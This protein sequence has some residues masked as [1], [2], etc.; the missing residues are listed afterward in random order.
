MKVLV[1]TQFHLGIGTQFMYHVHG[2]YVPSLRNVSTAQSL[3]AKS[4]EGLK[5]LVNGGPRAQ[6]MVR[7]W[8][9]GSA[10]WVFSM[11]VLGGV[12]RL[13][14]S[15]LSMTDWKFSGGLPPLSDEEWLQEFEKYKQSPEYKRSVKE[16]N[17]TCICSIA[18]GL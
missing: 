13:T 2:Q 5:L 6:K 8:L 17:S 10:A 16:K 12:T 15:G 1:L 7:I 4:N 18:N 11:V 9:F 14:R 3:N